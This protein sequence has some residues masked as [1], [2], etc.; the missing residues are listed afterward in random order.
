M[1]TL[2]VMVMTRS[3]GTS[4]VIK[5]IHMVAPIPAEETE[6]KLGD[7][8]KVTQMKDRDTAHVSL[9]NRKLSPHRRLWS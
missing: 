7:L 6:S 4:H 8:F 3:P 2:L 1:L 5:Q 9:A